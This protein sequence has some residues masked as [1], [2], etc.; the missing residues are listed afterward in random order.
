M[1]EALTD[2]A[3]QAV[4]PPESGRIEIADL[5]CAGLA[6]R[7]SSA[8]NRSWCFRFRDPATGKTTRATIGPYPAVGL[9]DA[10]K[11][12]DGLRKKVVRGVNPVQAKRQ[13]RAEAHRKTFA[14]LAERYLTEHAYRRKR[15]RSAAEDERN[16][17]KHVLPAW[18]KRPYESIARRDVIELLEAIVTA[19]TPIA[20]NRVHAVVSTVFSFA[21]D[22]DLVQAN[23]AA[24]LR[25]RGV[26]TRKTRV[27]SDDELR[28][29]WRQCVLPPVSHTVGLALRL[30]LL[31]GM[32]PGEVAG[33]RRT[34]VEHLN[35][36]R[37][38][39]TIAGERTKNGK[40][41]Y[42]PLA[43]L[44]VKTL[45][46]AIGLAGNADRV[47][48]VESHALSVAMRRL[49]DRLP[50]APGADTWH[51]HSPT[52]HDLRRTCATRLASLGV[53]G[54]DISAILNHTPQHITKQVYDKYDRVR[55]KRAAL[56][57]WAAA[58]IALNRVV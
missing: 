41:H 1:Q 48:G 18:G 14:A 22:C 44:A 12:A 20:A 47:F 27:L 40:A 37:A 42:V 3:V 53:P 36:E 39:L 28:L 10:R 56:T 23:P 51:A 25:K 9:A 7:I 30:C 49:A 26:E 16:L 35:N 54:E 6:L 58:L 13:D 50:D 8:G 29:F 17:R 21:V 33:L 57:A 31:T 2:R 52:P 5:R 4:R 15:P 24:R 19:G 32:R 43:P 11:A 45:Q 34:E 55:E 38:A 46:E